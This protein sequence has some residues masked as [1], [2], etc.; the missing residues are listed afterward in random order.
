[1]SPAGSRQSARAAAPD[2]GSWKRSTSRVE[3]TNGGGRRAC[4]PARAHGQIH[5]ADDTTCLTGSDVRLLA[6]LYNAFVVQRG[7]DPRTGG[8][9]QASSDAPTLRSPPV[10][11]G[12][13]GQ[14]VDDKRKARLALDDLRARLRTAPG[15][16]HEWLDMAFVREDERARAHLGR[17]AYRPQAPKTWRM[18]PPE[19][20]SNFDIHDAMVQ[21][22]QSVPDFAFL[23]VY[24][25]DFAQVLEDGTCV[26]A[27][28]CSL[29]VERLWH[30]GR[31]QLGVVLNTDKHY[32]DGSHWVCC[33]VNIDPRPGSNFF[34]LFYYDSVCKRVPAEVH[35]LYHEL[36]TEV[37]RL[38]GQEAASRFRMETNPVRRQFSNTECGIFTMLFLLSC[39]SG[40]DCDYVCRSMGL[41]DHVH[42]MRGILFR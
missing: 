32:Q 10:D 20:L 36:R 17:T 28:M 24:P 5:T 19:W 15:D 39:I 18:N 11:A 26:S 38:F 12:G 7:G 16:E 22:E 29:S 34:G 8:P 37:E 42:A 40:L 23:G 9:L 41:D 2:L 3:S 30:Q 14:D 27:E 25:I 6:S 1:M 31:R 13:S 35:R 21:Y 33:Y 4:S